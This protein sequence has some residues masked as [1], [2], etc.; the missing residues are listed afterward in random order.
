MLSYTDVNVMIVGES[1][2]GK[3]L[4]ASAVH[5]YRTTLL[6]TVRLQRWT[7]HTKQVTFMLRL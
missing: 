4:V 1:G 2:T 6:T 3:E 5:Q 7:H